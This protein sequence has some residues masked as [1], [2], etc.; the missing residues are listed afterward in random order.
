MIIPFVWISLFVNIWYI[1][2]EQKIGNI[3]LTVAL[4]LLALQCCAFVGIFGFNMMCTTLGWGEQF[5]EET[6][7]RLQEAQAIGSVWM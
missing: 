7:Y 6:D 2:V 5:P 1:V 3:L 4:D